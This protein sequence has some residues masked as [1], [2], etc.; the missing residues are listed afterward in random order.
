LIGCRIGGQNCIPLVT[1][2]KERE[3]KSLRY[4]ALHTL[5]TLS[6][7]SIMHQLH[8]TRTHVRGYKI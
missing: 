8:V 1:K 7:I 4:A 5:Y 6:E 2:Y 3:Q